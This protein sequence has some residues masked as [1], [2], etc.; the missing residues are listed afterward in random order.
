VIVLLVQLLIAWVALVL[1]VGW[2]S[3]LLVHW[4]LCHCDEWMVA[5]GNEKGN[6]KLKVEGENGNNE[7]MR[8]KRVRSKPRGSF[9]ISTIQQY[10]KNMDPNMLERLMSPQ[11]RAWFLPFADLLFY[12][13]CSAEATVHQMKGRY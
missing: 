13:R 10:C 11:D 3:R 6:Q 7:L 2:C 8:A 12:A 5:S 9:L 4:L 1:H